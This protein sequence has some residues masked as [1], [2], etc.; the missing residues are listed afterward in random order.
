MQMKRFVTK[1]II[2]LLSLPACWFIVLGICAKQPTAFRH[3]IGTESLKGGTWRRTQEWNENMDLRRDVDVLF[4][5]SST[6]YCGIDPHALASHGLKGF[7]FC[8]S[9]QRL[10]TSHLLLNAALSESQPQMVVI[11]LFPE[12]WPGALHG[13]EPARDWALNADRGHSAA[14]SEAI[15]DNA[16]LSGNVYNTLL[17]VAQSLNARIGW[18]VHS[19]LDDAR[20][21]YK[22]LGFVERHY[23]PLELSPDCHHFQSFAFDEQLCAVLGQIQQITSRSDA[24]LILILPPEL[25]PAPFERPTCWAGLRVIDGNDWPGAQNPAFF[26]DE[27]HLVAAGAEAYS[28]WLAQELAQANPF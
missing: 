5:G 18:R 23:P 13:V 10:G 25:C 8:S 2:F 16:W 27:H 28:T 1:G 24:A 7:N 20:S 12:L 3:L 9:G 22:G 26:Y 6:C 4:F 21:H 19:R 14:W 17:A 11:D 15:L